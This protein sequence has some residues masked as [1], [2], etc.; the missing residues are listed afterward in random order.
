[1]MTKIQ[2]MRPERKGLNASSRRFIPMWFLASAGVHSIPNIQAK[3]K[4]TTVTYHLS[5]LEVSKSGAAD[6]QISINYIG[7][8]A[9]GS[10]VIWNL[11]SLRFSFL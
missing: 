5:N 4:S 6:V 1:M 2:Q 7:K 3:G 10:H 11:E 8:F 9:L